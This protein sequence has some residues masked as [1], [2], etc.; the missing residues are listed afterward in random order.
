VAA[1]EPPQVAALQCASG[2]GLFA[3]STRPSAIRRQSM[4]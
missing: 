3:W 4:G 2:L 1:G